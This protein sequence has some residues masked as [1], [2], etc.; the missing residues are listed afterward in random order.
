MYN[1]RI[2]KRIVNEIAVSDSK[3]EDATNRYS[4]LS[5]WF[6][7]GD[8]KLN[9]Y[10]PIIYT[11]GSFSLGTAINPLV[12]EKYDLDIMCCLQNLKTTDITECRLKQLVGDEVKE[13]ASDYG[14]DQ[15]E[16]HTRA[17]TIN[18]NEKSKFQMDV[19][20]SIPT[21][22]GSSVYLTYK[23]TDLYNQM[24]TPWEKISN[25][26]GYLEWFLNKCRE[27]IL[28][29]KKKFSDTNK[30]EIEKVPDYKVK[31]ILQ[32]V[33]MLLKR[34]RDV[35]FDNLEDCIEKDKKVSSIIITTLAAEQ[36]KGEKELVTTFINIVENLENAIKVRN[37]SVYENFKYSKGYVIGNRDFKIV[38]PSNPS[39]DF[40]DK[41]REDPYRKRAFFMWLEQLKDDVSKLKLFLNGNETGL[42]IL[43]KMFGTSIEIK[44]REFL[45]EDISK[46]EESY[47]KKLQYPINLI[48]TANIKAYASSKTI[49]NLENS[50]LVP[51]IISSNEPISKGKNLLFVAETTLKE[52]YDVYWQIANKEREAIENDAIRGEIVQNNKYINGYIARYQHKEETSYKGTHWVRCFIVKNGV[53]CARSDKFYVKIL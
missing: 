31:S 6:G 15:P 41:W 25:P 24:H 8:S 50:E 17:W 27:N 45:V 38:N 36:Y 42:G 33:V 5:H 40:T 1:E 28:E 46:N 21:G 22:N 14:M 49:F 53:C 43:K 12:G 19:I 2:L 52:P 37:N 32:E 26:K 13:Y 39:E 7:R 9:L 51:Y 4:S 20:P 10:R 18:Y 29:R 16:D 3:Y 35:F 44:L 47:I 34:H 30:I 11:H 23:D 48:A